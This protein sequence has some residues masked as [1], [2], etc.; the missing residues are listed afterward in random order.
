MFTFLLATHHFFY[1]CLCT[2]YCGLVWLSP[3]AGNRVLLINY[4]FYFFFP[5][6]PAQLEFFFFFFPLVV[7]YISSSLTCSSS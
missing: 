2:V 6:R 5:F 1:L 4:S 7:S 3:R